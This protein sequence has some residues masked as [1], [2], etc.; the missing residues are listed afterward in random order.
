MLPTKCTYVSI[1][2]YFCFR[3]LFVEC[4]CDHEQ[5]SRDYI[6]TLSGPLGLFAYLPSFYNTSTADFSYPTSPL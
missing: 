5:A 4:G 3:S 2:P 1:A 6:T